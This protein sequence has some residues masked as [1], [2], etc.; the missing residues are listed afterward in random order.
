MP[1]REEQA[2]HEAAMRGTF[3]LHKAA[4]EGYDT[5][6]VQ[7]LLDAGVAVDARKVIEG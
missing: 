4:Y 3:A 2:L 1:Q 5:T 7:T 6:V